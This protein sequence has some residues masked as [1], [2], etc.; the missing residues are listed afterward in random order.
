MWNRP[1]VII[2]GGPSFSLK[3]TR[4]IGMARAQ[5]R[6]FVVTV[7]DAVYPCWYADVA[8]ACDRRWWDHHAGLK[9]FHGLKLSLERT[10]FQDVTTLENTGPEG[11]DPD[12]WK[13]RSGGNGG[14][15]AIQVAAH[16][17]APKVIL[18]GYDM[19]GGHWFGEH[20]SEIRSTLAPQT[21]ANMIRGFAVLGDALA[22]RGVKIFNAT[23][24][25]AITA[26]PRVSLEEVL[27]G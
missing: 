12:P 22:K 25:S 4:L 13:I 1:A 15:Q 18:V 9:Y 7:N 16:L 23:P 3:D 6:I 8:Y 21:R 20:P 17:G 27:R 2:A 24:G 19:Q 26:F 5:N 10:D 11:Y 14:Y